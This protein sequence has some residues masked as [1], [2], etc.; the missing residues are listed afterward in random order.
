MGGNL[1]TNLGAPVTGTDAANKNYVDSVVT[2]LS[3]KQAVRAA[4][5]GPI[6]LSTDAE[7]GDTIDGVT[8]A[9]GDR[10][11]IK[12]QV[13]QTQ[14]GIYVV[15]ASGVPVR[16]SDAYTGAELRGASVYVEEGTV[17]QDTGW[18]QTT[19]GTIT[20]GSTNIVWAQFSGSGSYTAG[21]GL[22]L[23][24]NTFSLTSPVVTSLGGTGLT[25]IGTANQVL[26]VNAGATGLE[27]KTVTAGTG[28]SVVH[29]AGTI[30]VN[31]T[32]VTS[33]GLSAPSIFTVSGSP[34]TTTGTLTLTLAS[35]AANTVF[36]APNGTPGTPSFRTLVFADLPIQLYREN[37]SSPTTPSATGTNAVAIGSGS[38]ASATHG[39]AMGPGSSASIFGS[40]AQANG[41]FTGAGD[42]QKVDVVL[43]N[44]TTSAATTE[45]FLDGQAATQ[46]LVIPNNSVVTFEIMVAARRT[47]A[48]GGG[49]GY[50]FH[51]VIRK[52]TTAAST[53]FVGTPSKVILG[54]TNASWNADVVADTTNGSL[55]VNVTGEAGK[56]I[57]W[58]AVTMLAVVTN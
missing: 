40:K 34:V 25:S 1:V 28:I 18:L 33:V 52:D 16:A 58:V 13:D 21:T 46:R 56:T 20:I 38:A 14:N 10:I 5:T 27:Y 48:N 39:V 17:N 11:L 24:G 29:G 3:W 51:G 30:T 47:D 44:E 15:Q 4:T 9:T 50:R 43:R 32:G 6:T 53:T 36:A 8:L 57:R 45:L 31:N 12:D 55:R 2:G 23:S 35:Q 37:P 19:D 54:E 26:G 7:A 42:A 49:A 41:Q 22:T